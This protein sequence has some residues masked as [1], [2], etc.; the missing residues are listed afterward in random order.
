MASHSRL[1]RAA[2]DLLRLPALRLG[3]RVNQIGEAL[4]L[5][6]IHLA[7]QERAPGEFAGLGRPQARH[8]VKRTQQARPGRSPAGNM[9]LDDILAGEAPRRREADD[10]GPVDRS[11]E[12]DR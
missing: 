4:D 6:Q 7:V 12:S 1:Q 8:G 11:A 2:G 5:G 3:L 9:Q 10:Q